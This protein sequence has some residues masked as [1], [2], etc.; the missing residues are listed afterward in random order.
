MGCAIIAERKAPTL[1]IE[2][3][4]QHVEQW[5]E[6]LIALLGIDKSRSVYMVGEPDEN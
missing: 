1:I 5:Q 4:D 6:Q 3:R 2:H